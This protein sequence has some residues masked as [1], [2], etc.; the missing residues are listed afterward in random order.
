[1]RSRSRIF[2]SL[3][4]PRKN[5]ENYPHPRFGNRRKHSPLDKQS[6][7]VSSESVLAKVSV[8]LLATASL[9]RVTL[10]LLFSSLLFSSLLFS[11]L[12][13]SSLPSTLTLVLSRISSASCSHLSCFSFECHGRYAS[14]CRMSS[15]GVVKAVD[16]L[17]QCLRD[18]ATRCQVCRQISSAF[19]VLK[20]V[21][22]AALS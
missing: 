4:W 8:T 13:F 12:L 20:K 7:R 3:F 14:C 2:V 10:G 15:S 1:M 17:K 11:S 5:D 22:T 19:S 16:V 18:L 9:T 21:S 6:S